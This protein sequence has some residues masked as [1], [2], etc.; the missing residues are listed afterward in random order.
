MPQ[1]CPSPE[2]GRQERGSKRAEDKV[3]VPHQGALD[4]LDVIRPTGVSLCMELA[5]HSSSYG[6]I[7]S[8]ECPSRGRRK[9]WALISLSRSLTLTARLR[10]DSGMVGR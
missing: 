1:E 2:A 9:G 5:Q 4:S 7:G 3:Q 10:P 6:P 8:A